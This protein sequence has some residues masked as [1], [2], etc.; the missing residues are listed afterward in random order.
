MRYLPHVLEKLRALTPPGEE[1][2]IAALIQHR[3]LN[4][5][6]APE[7][8]DWHAVAR[9]LRMHLD[10]RLKEKWVQQVLAKWRR[11]PA[12]SRI[13]IGILGTGE[14]YACRRCYGKLGAFE[15]HGGICTNCRAKPIAEDL[16]G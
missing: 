14:S 11:D 4:L 10:H 2:F 9:T 16:E 8:C 13:Q 15:E 5:Y 6:N 1:A 3:E 12:P 7:A